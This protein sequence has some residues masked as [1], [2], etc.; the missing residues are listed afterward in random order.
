MPRGAH[1]HIGLYVYRRE[2][3]LRYPILAVTPLES[4]EK[5]EQLR[6]IEHGYRIHV[7]VTTQPSMGVDTQEDLEKVRKIVARLEE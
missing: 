7:A 5:L 4:M 1:K 3:L 2:F 6:A